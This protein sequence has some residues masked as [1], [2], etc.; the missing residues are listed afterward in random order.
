MSAAQKIRTGLVMVPF[1]LIALSGCGSARYVVQDPQGGIVAIPSNSNYW[2][3]H[4]RDGAEK[5][6]RQKCP[7]GYIIDREE[8]VVV[9][10][11]TTG[12][13]RTDTN[14]YDVGRRRFAPAGTVTVS[15]TRHTTN[16]KD[17]TEYRITFHAKDAAPDSPPIRVTGGTQ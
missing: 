9:G 3:T 7:A 4:Y 6:M 2:P 14:S 5:L 16:T 13:T 11:T 17:Q 1:L 8:E 12:S 15:D 10:Q